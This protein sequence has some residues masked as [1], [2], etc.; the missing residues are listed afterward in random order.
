MFPD[1]GEVALCGRHPVRSSRT[2]SSPELYTPGVPSVRPAGPSAVAGWL[3]RTYQLMW[4]VSSPAGCRARL[5]MEFV[6]CW[7]V[8]RVLSQLVAWSEESQF[9]HPP[10]GGRHRSPGGGVLSVRM[11]VDGAVSEGGFLWGWEACGQRRPAAMWDHG[12]SGHMTGV[13]CG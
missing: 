13:S 1:L 9:W 3:L 8:G 11:P 2:L 5:S 4:Q 7:W 12:L 10:A 6:D